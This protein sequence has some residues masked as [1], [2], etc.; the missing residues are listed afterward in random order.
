MSIDMD[1]AVAQYTASAPGASQAVLLPDPAPEPIWHPII[2]VDDHLLEP[3]DLFAHRLPRQLVQAA[4]RAVPNDAGTP[5]WMIDG[6]PVAVTVTNG[7]V[8]RPMSEW[9][10]GPQRFD[11]FRTGVYDPALR[12][13]DMDLCGIWGSLCF[14]SIVFGFCGSRLAR[15][16]DRELGLACVRAYNDWVIDTWCAAAPDRYIPCQLPWMA[17]PEVAAAEIRRNAAR[18]VRAV[19][20]SEN[21]EIRGF[22][23][24]H[25]GAWDAF[26]AACA[27][28]E[29]VVNLHVGSSGFIESPSQFTPDDARAA[30]FPVN[31]VKASVDWVYSGVPLRFP[32][33]RI[34]LSE[35]GVS[36]VPM[37]M[38]RLTRAYRQVES[39][40]R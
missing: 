17:D 27:E 6:T 38:E 34:V 15:M 35:G 16:K 39:S 5:V 26:F 1:I 2:S 9:N 11:Q 14:P 33:L 21:P 18:G 25:T 31:A 3:F 30:L 7:A 20:F 29:T 40:T 37:V 13:K 22:P 19:T 28:T 8:G 23:S 36:W 10:G 4:P 32:S 24:I 12:L